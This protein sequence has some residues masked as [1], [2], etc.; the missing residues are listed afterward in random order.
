MSNQISLNPEEYHYNNNPQSS[1]SSA[2]FHISTYDQDDEIEPSSPFLLDLEPL[3][4][5]HIQRVS[6]EDELNLY[7]KRKTCKIYWTLFI[8]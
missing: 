7:V 2:R 1:S 4:P 6:S 8:W 5:I 3:T